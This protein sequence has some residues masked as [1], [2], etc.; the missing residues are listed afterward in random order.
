MLRISRFCAAANMSTSSSDGASGSQA[1]S[2]LW[3]DFES[4]SDSDMGVLQMSPASWRRLSSLPKTRGGR[5]RPRCAG[6]FSILAAPKSRLWI[7]TDWRLE[8]QRRLRSHRRFLSTFGFF[9]AFTVGGALACGDLVQSPPL[10]FHPDVGVAGKH[11]ARDVPGN[12]HDHL[13]ARARLRKLRDQRVPIVVPPPDDLSFV[14][15]LGPSCPQRRNGAG[16]I[17]RLPL[18]SGENVPLRLALTEPPDVP[19]GVRLQGDHDRIVQRDH[20]PRA[21]VGL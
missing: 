5:R 17:I 9:L 12:A 15:D 19:R 21:R 11:C 18:P 1:S 6:S 8:Y 13:V 4:V 2:I 16:G 3:V 10:C 14:A 7:D 20:A